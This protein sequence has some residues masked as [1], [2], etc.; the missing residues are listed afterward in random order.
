MTRL[1]PILVLVAFGTA[2]AASALSVGNLECEHLADP[3]GVD[4]PRPRLSWILH[5]NRRCQIQKAYRVI[6]ASSLAGLEHLRG[7]LWDSGLVRSSRSVLIPYSGKPLASRQTCWWRV[8]VWDAHGS[9][10]PWSA[11]ARWEMGLLAPGDWKAKWIGL[12]RGGDPERRLPARMLRREFILQKPV[13]RARA[14]VC[15]L[16][17]FELYLNGRK[18]GDHVLD[19]A[20]SQYDKRVFYVEFDVSRLLKK[21]AN[22]VGVVLGNGRYYAPRLTV[23]IAT[24]SF[25]YPKLLLQIEAQHPDGSRT[26]VVSDEHW[27]VTDDGPIRANNEYDGEQYDARK[28]LPGWCRP[29]FDDSSWQPAQRVEGPSGV[30]RSQMA[31]PIRVVQTLRPVRVKR[32]TAGSWLVDMGQN[33]V[34]WCRISVAGPRGATVTLRHAERLNPDGTLYVA[35]LRSAKATDTYT[36]AGKPTETWEPR[37]T[38][39]GFRYVEVS[40]LPHSER[41]PSIVGRVVHDALQPAGSFSCGSK[42]VNRIWRNIRWSFRGN[43]RSIPTD[44]PQRDE[45]QG[46]LG[47]RSAES[48]GESYLFDVSTFYS[49]WL[50][51]IRDAQRADGSIPDVAPTYW[52]LYND[53]VTW[54]STFIIIPGM[55]YDQYGDA[56]AIRANYAA[57][58]RWVHHMERYL[59]GDLMPRDSYGDWCVPPEAPNLIHTLDPARLTDGTL[60]ATAYYWYDLK[61]LAR[62]AKLAG[63]PSDAQA[64]EDLAHRIQ[65]AFNQRFFQPVLDRYGNGS[66][67]STLLPLALGL[68]PIQNRQRLC[69]QLV[70]QIEHKGSPE[71]GVGLIGC[72]WLMQTLSRCGHADVAWALANRMQYPSWGHMIRKGATTIWELWNGD[73][74][75]PAM[76][77]YNHV[78]LVGDL[79]TWL[80]EDVAGI[81]PDPARP[82]FRHILMHPRAVM[83]IG[84]AW[85]VHFSPYGRIE[86][87]WNVHNGLFRWDVE[88]PVN[89]TATLWIP[90]AK[91]TV[92][93]EGG[94]PASRAAG[95]QLLRSEP[96]VVVVE[97][98]SGRY[99]FTSRT[100]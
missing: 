85:A 59:A 1:L 35:N 94:R 20:L 3:L 64:Y 27:R 8:R 99:H 77:S 89:A 24:R 23:P 88:V 75:D 90:A 32:L 30:L 71:I 45:R 86:S 43:Y 61:L 21:G 10:S 34:G 36:L 13:T 2:K 91:N 17:L 38:Y 100:P 65:Q 56:A 37:F 60:I 5:S 96:G 83:K 50:D 14:Y 51:D 68:A 29:H 42:L 70:R 81:A 40:G 80:Y 49:R 92:V 52:T 78:M 95:V 74:A 39:H 54:P 12:E 18:V 97:V 47:D 57:M 63:A 72:Q 87:R 53:D 62:Y 4:V 79:L 15:G 82:G 22:A 41:P 28:A 9:P 58:K 16:G 55:L 33:M 48:R 69:A 93:L 98:R 46:W 84:R 73:T 26:L 19:P 44:C 6:V 76:N 7:D 11:P 25:G 67:T 31:P 66:Q